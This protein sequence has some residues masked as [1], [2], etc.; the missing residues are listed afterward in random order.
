MIEGNDSPA[1]DRRRIDSD[2]F[3]RMD[4]QV[5]VGRPTIDVVEAVAAATGREPMDLPPLQQHVDADALDA[6]LDRD[7]DGRYVRVSFRYN[8]LR[9]DADS[10]GRIDVR[11]ENQ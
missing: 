5:Q 2:E 4:G 10:A 9:I 7:G 6:L 8:D 11:I 1:G 3:Y